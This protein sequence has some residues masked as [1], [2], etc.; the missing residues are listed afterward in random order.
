MSHMTMRVQPGDT[1]DILVNTPSG[2][3]EKIHVDV[4]EAQDF[5]QRIDKRLDYLSTEVR[6]LK[7]ALLPKGTDHEEAKPDV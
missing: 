4:M 5:K 1:I 2:K 3:T 6:E 7:K